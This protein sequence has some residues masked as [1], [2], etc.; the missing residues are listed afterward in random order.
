MKSVASRRVAAEISVWELKWL[1]GGIATLSIWKGWPSTILY[2]SFTFML[3]PVTLHRLWL[4]DITKI[5]IKF[6]ET[7]FYVHACFLLDDDNFLIQL[8]WRDLSEFSRCVKS[9]N[10][11]TSLC[12]SAIKMNAFIIVATCTMRVIGIIRPMERVIAPFSQCY[13]VINAKAAFLHCRE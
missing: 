4:K 10:G 13:C 11:I 6:A 12:S 9:L 7:Y 5:C 3:S 1:R 2:E 8:R